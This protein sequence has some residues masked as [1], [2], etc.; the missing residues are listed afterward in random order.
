[1]ASGDLLHG[2]VIVKYHGW[3]TSGCSCAMHARAAAFVVLSKECIS[4][5]LLS[6]ASYVKQ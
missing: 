3:G 1:M 5:D 6:N 4:Y 2:A